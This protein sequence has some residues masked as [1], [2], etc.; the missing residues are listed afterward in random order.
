ML[1]KSLEFHGLN[2]C[3]SSVH[4]RGQ[5]SWLRASLGVYLLTL[6]V[7]WPTSHTIAAGQSISAPT[8][9]F[10]AVQGAVN[11][12]NTGDVVNIPAGT[13]DW[14]SNTLTVPG[15]VSL[16]GAG[17]TST[18]I[19]GSS[20]TNDLIT[21]DCSNGKTSN[22]SDMTLIGKANPAIW[23]G[24]LTLLNGCKDFMVFNSKFSDF[25][26]HG[27]SVEGNSRG[28]I[29]NNNFFNNF[30]AGQTGGTTGYGVVVYGDSTW[31]PLELGT[32]NAVFVEDNIF[33]GNRHNIASNNGSRYVFRHN[34]VTAPEPV[35]NFAL[36][37]AHGFTSSPRG[38][39]SWE[40]YNNTFSTNLLTSDA[41]RTVM[42][43][44]GGDGVIFNNIL[45]NPHTVSRT[46]ELWAPQQTSTYPAKDQMTSGYFWNNSPNILCNDAPANFV[47][48]R[49]YF[50]YARPGYAPYAYP[51]PLRTS[52]ALTPP[53]SPSNLSVQ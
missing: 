41:A 17:R 42:G 12:G 37:D 40:V 18:I 9:A 25:V 48:G 2:W 31:P 32:A 5:S 29:F 1:L 16:R 23:D 50:L 7:V 30:R 8:C 27:L 28:V 22:F 6:L 34:T 51:H 43:I 10:S 21:I 39:R 53:Q 3:P 11:S 36:V 14:G 45:L 13:C 4:L 20:G 19:R 46:I 26:N 44:G 52:D 24:G 33:S 47:E 35:K 38:S 49:D 15:G